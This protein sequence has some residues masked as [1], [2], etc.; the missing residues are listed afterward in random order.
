MVQTVIASEAQMPH[1]KKYLYAL[2]ANFVSIV[3][4]KVSESA[5]SEKPDFL[6]LPEILLDGQNINESG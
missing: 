6:L 1:I 5:E 4:S 2:P 3:S